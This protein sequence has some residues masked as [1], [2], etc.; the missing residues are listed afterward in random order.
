[1]LELKSAV[2][3][4]HWDKNID[5]VIFARIRVN[6]MSRN[7]HS[8]LRC[9]ALNSVTVV[10]YFCPVILGVIT[11]FYFHYFLLNVLCKRRRYLKII[12]EIT[13]HLLLVLFYYN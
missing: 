9:T 7:C 5:S 4:G 12:S 3:P 1:M 6:I 10:N 2:Q 11:V 13:E 8:V